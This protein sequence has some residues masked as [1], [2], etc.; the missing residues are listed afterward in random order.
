MK[1]D[2]KLGWSMQEGPWLVVLATAASASDLPGPSTSGQSL[3][4][5]RDAGII[6][7]TI[8]CHPLSSD[9]SCKDFRLLAYLHFEIGCALCISVR[10]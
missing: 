8:W 3:L 10:V 4:Q 1:G 6:S 7:F 9:Q 5:D 2:I